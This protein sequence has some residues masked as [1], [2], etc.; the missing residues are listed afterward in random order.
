MHRDDRKTPFDTFVLRMLAQEG[1]QPGPIPLFVV[2]RYLHFPVWFY[3]ETLE[4]KK[5]TGFSVHFTV[6]ELERLAKRAAAFEVHRTSTIDEARGTHF[7]LATGSYS[8]KQKVTP[9]AIM[10]QRGCQV[11]PELKVGDRYQTM[12]AFPVWCNPGV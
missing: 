7:W 10:T 5:N 6:P 2:D 11:G 1:D 12:T 3:L 9:Q 8:W 4:A